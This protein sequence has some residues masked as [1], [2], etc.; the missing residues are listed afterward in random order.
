MIEPASA[1]VAL[2]TGRLSGEAIVRTERR[3]CDLV[4]LY[5]DE[6]ARK[7]LDQDQIVYRVE[8]HAVAGESAPGG[9]FFGTS[10]LEPGRVGDEYFMTKG[11]F[12]SKREAAEYYWGVCGQGA[13]VFMDEDRRCWVEQ[14]APGSLHYIPGGVAH[15][16]CNVG[17]SEL[18]VG[19][20]WPADAGHDYSSIA[21]RGFSARVKR[22]DGRP[23]LVPERTP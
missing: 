11:H 22:V 6:T 3:L 16:L 7:A 17:D 10:F 13:L 20:C 19:A 4:G 23:Q 2:S 5:A 14:V 9:L 8:M 1:H 18:V 15:R 12:H 21:E